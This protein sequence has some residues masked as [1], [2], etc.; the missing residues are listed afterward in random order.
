MEQDLDAARIE[1]ATHDDKEAVMALYRAM[2]GLPG[3]TWNEHYPTAD[4]LERDLDAGN[5]F[6][7]RDAAGEILATIAIDQDEDVEA[8]PHWSGAPGEYRELA[9]L[10]VRRDIQSRGL[11]RRM[12]AFGM[13]ELERRGCIGVHFLVSPGNP[14]ALAAYAVFGF[15][16]VGSAELYGQ[17]WYCYEKRF[18][19][20]QKL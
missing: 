9:R 20:K 16:H 11:A 5:V 1:P 3:C 17:S 14:R 6:V 2:I 15:D 12:L 4:L 19:K 13:E 7:L 18:D 10:C 8:L